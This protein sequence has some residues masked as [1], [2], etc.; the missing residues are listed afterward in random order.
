MF[1]VNSGIFFAFQNKALKGKKQDTG[2]EVLFSELKV[3]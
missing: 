3:Q 2:V 1:A